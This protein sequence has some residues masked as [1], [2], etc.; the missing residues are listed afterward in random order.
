MSGVRRKETLRRTVAGVL[1]V[2]FGAGVGVALAQVGG[3]L[4]PARNVALPCELL[5]TPGTVP[6][7]AKNIAHLANVCGFVGTDVEFQSR[8]AND[9]THDYAFVGT[10][11]AGMR[12]F[13]ITD[14]AHPH[15]A[16][17]YADP[18]WQNDVQVRGNLAVVGFDP[19]SG[20]N[21]SAS[22]CLQGKRASGG[23]D[24]VK[25]TYDSV[26][27][28]FTTTLVDCVSA[29]PSGGAHN[30]TLDPR[31]EWLAIVNP[32]GHGSVDVV[33]LRGAPTRTYRIVQEA[34][35]TNTACTSAQLAPARCIS[36]GRAGTWSPHDVSFSNDGSRM[37]VSAIGNDTVIV[38]VSGVLS[39]T[40]T[41]IGVVPNDRNGGGVANDRNDIS[42][43]HQS[44]P[45]SDEA[46]VGITD[47]RGGGLQ[48][49]RCNTDPNGVIGGIHFWSLPVTGVADTSKRL[50]AWF[51]PNPGLLADPLSGALAGLGRLER[52]CTIHVFRMGGNGTAGPGPIQAGFDGVSTLP[53]R[54]L[55]SAH[56]GAGVWHI[57]FS[58]PSSGLDG[59]AEDPQSTWGNTRGWNVMPGAETWSAKEYK[60]FIYTGD[61]GRGFDVYS[62]TGCDGLG[63]VVVPRNTPGTASGGGQVT[64]DLAELTILSGSAAGGKATF[65]FTAAY[66]TGQVAPT[67]DLTFSEKGGSGKKVTSTSID[68]FDVVGTKAT[69]TGR[70]TVNG[71]PGVRFFV[72]VEDLGEPGRADTFRI[73]LQDG[74]AAGGVLLK[75]NI[76]VS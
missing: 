28:N 69:F 13:D 48:E 70:A 22:T 8:T 76:E 20:A 71:V 18:G 74:Y 52:A 15:S 10:M 63:C 19:I 43:A 4:D 32:R 14:P 45:S 34:T 5:S 33:D 49:T 29:S 54:Q 17:G 46:I 50:G 56:Y 51:Y 66:R 27:A 75:G 42:I 58:G 60:G 72:Q 2:L 59:I 11:G 30:A 35:L 6:R 61:M 64:D 16:G 3:E 9:G 41:V 44:D 37:Y 36:T 7:S 1:A 40:A 26:T 39:G 24:I 55:V 47:E 12:I 53:A 21:P 68:G 23:V 62:F 57:D 38:D 25:L 73:V 31:G 67:G 65:R